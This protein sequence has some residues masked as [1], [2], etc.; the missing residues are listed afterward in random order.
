MLIA[1]S[2][3]KDLYLLSVDGSTVTALPTAPDSIPQAVVF[4]PEN[5]TVL[6]YDE[7]MSALKQTNIRDKISATVHSF[8][9]GVIICYI[10]VID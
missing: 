1:D 5:D 8:G 2:Y 6:W 3:G 10:P 9:S 4:V 7:K